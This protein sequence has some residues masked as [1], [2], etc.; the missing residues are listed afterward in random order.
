M[1]RLADGLSVFSGSVPGVMSE[2]DKN[3]IAMISKEY[4]SSTTI[5]CAD[6]EYCMPCPHGV[7][8]KA[9]FAL[10]NKYRNTMDT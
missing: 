10:Y 4:G 8:I 7:M 3:L 1:E 6:S 5:P 2:K 9:V